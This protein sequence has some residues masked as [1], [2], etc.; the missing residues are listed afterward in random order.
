MAII[1]H[2]SKNTGKTGDAIDCDTL[3]SWTLDTEQCRITQTPTQHSIWLNVTWYFT[4][5]K[6]MIKARRYARHLQE[7]T[8]RYHTGARMT[9][10]KCCNESQLPGSHQCVFIA[11]H[12]YR[13]WLGTPPPNSSE[14]NSLDTQ[15]NCYGHSLL[16]LS[17][18]AD[19][20]QQCEISTYYQNSPTKPICIR[21]QV[22]QVVIQQTINTCTM[23]LQWPFPGSN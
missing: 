12:A 9:T 20:C 16:A 4:M 14:W 5:K 7:H 8:I 10:V 18:I 15:L 22:Y 19:S 13:H 6:F 11:H 17:Q 2:A 21:L 1:G 3:V 23:S